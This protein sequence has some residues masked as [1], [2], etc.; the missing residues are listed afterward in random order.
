MS[1]KGVFF[2]SSWYDIIKD[3]P[4]DDFCE[5]AK[6]VIE[7]GITRKNP[8]FSNQGLF[9]AFKLIA[10]ELER[11][12]EKGKNYSETQS[13]NGKKGGAPLGNQNAKKQPKTTQTTQNNPNKVDKDKDKDEDEDIDKDEDKEES[14]SSSLFL[15]IYNQTSKPFGNVSLSESQAETISGRTEAE[16]KTF[17]GEVEQSEWLKTQP[18]GKVLNLFDNVVSGNYR[19]DKQN[20][21]TIGNIGKNFDKW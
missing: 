13:N 15:N 20:N 7:F 6:A 8:T 18:F 19:G 1:E 12:E 9:L 2:F 21:T 17:W 4:N 14:L 5:L 3:L 16:I 10:A 11:Y